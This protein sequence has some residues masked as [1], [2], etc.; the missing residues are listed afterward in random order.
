MHRSTDENLLRMPSLNATP[1]CSKTL[2]RFN[3]STQRCVIYPL[4]YEALQPFTEALSKTRSLCIVVF[5]DL[6]L[7]TSRRTS[8]SCPSFIA[9]DC[10][11]PPVLTSWFLPHAGPHLATVHF[12]SQELGHGTRYR[13]VSPPRRPS[14][15][16]DDFWKIICS[17]D[18][19]VQ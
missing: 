19:C 10:V 9:S 1:T 16:S 17:S 12:R 7:N 3:E 15:H 14:L 5:M 2:Q 11:R 4:G 18:N 8:G 13:P 6:A